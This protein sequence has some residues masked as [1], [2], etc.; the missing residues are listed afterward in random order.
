MRLLCCRFRTYS[1]HVHI[2]QMYILDYT[3]EY[4]RIRPAQQ[5][6]ILDRMQP[7]RAEKAA[8]AAEER[9]KRCPCVVFSPC[10][11]WDAA[12]VAVLLRAK[13]LFSSAGGCLKLYA[14]VLCCCRV[15]RGILHYTMAQALSIANQIY[16]YTIMYVVLC[17]VGVLRFIFIVCVCS[18][19][20]AT[21]VIYVRIQNSLIRRRA[22][23]VAHARKYLCSIGTGDD[24][25]DSDTRRSIIIIVPYCA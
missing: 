24:D 18:R 5:H 11:F 17:C 15:L 9:G 12:A 19:A 4:V 23:R 13:S 16:L 7:S 25:D 21:F 20:R 1:E 3:I 14:A 8:T 10:S 22:W 2:I 6:N